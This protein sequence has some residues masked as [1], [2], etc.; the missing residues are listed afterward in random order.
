MIQRRVVKCAADG[1]VVSEYF[2]DISWEQVRVRRD[3]ALANSDWRALK[4]VT[5]PNAWK[6][7]RQAL[8]DLPGDHAEANDAADNWPVAPD[9]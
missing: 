9:E 8:R 5:L 1:S 4:D 2:D 3:Q 7:Y 6:D